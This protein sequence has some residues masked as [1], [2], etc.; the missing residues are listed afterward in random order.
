ML[1]GV[2]I[3]E[4]TAQPL[5]TLA[6]AL[7]NIV[8]R[9]VVDM[10]DL[11][12]RFDYKLTFTPESRPGAR[13]SEPQLESV[14]DAPAIFTALQEQLGLRLERQRGSVDVVIIDSIQRPSAD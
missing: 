4:A 2:G 5:R 14:P 7:T 1:I 8:G 13:G 9:P 6:A 11:V 10:T 12:G 3:L